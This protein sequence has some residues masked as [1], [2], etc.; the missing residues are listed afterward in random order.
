MRT[1][2]FATL[3][4]GTL[5]LEITGCALAT[6]ESGA[7][8]ESEPTQASAS[9]LS[10]LPWCSP[11]NTVYTRY[12]VVPDTQVPIA[13]ADGT[14]DRPFATIAAALDYAKARAVCGV[15]VSVMGG[16]AHVS[17]L[18]ITRP[19]I[20]ESGSEKGYVVGRI[21]NP[22]G[23]TL[24]IRNMGIVGQGQGVVQRG[25][26]LKL[27]GVDFLYASDP[28]SS[29]S[30]QDGTAVMVSG[31]AKATLF[32]VRAAYGAGPAVHAAGAGTQVWLKHCT[33]EFNRVNPHA[34][35][36]GSPSQRAHLGT[37]EISDAATAWFDDTTFRS[38]EANSLVVHNH[39]RAHV[40]SIVVKDTVRAGTLNHVEGTGIYVAHGGALELHNFSVSSQ[41]FGLWIYGGDVTASDGVFEHH[42]VPL[43]LA[44]S[45]L[46]GIPC[47]LGETY[48]YG[49][50][51]NEMYGSNDVSFVDNEQGHAVLGGEVPIPDVPP[52][53]CYLPNPPSYCAEAEEAVSC[54]TVPWV[55]G[56]FLPF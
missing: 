41:R 51:P 30:P 29:T 17:N 54:V 18:T 38:N 42:D 13:S 25:G 52:L 50:N 15:R 6:H 4:L 5:L 8:G 45:D 11:L 40:R 26:V 24:K 19:T 27:S 16:G 35:A 32:D 53:E 49:G 23:K 7:D 36:Q 3:A 34:V 31:G 22:A 47:L 28:S 46:D 48:S 21:D 33:F 56:A 14:P 2:A 55:D 44:G 20:L 9:E 43:A 39:G 12:Y 10:Y 1:P 37:V